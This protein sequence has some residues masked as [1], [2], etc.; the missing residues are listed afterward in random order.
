MGQFGPF[1]P[2][3]LDQAPLNRPIGPCFFRTRQGMGLM[4]R[5]NGNTFLGG[6]V[7]WW[8]ELASLLH[9]VLDSALKIDAHKSTKKAV[10][11]IAVTRADVDIKEINE[12]F[13]RIY[14]VS[15]TE[16]IEQTANG[17]YK[18]LLLTLISKGAWSR[19]IDGTPWERKCGLK[20]LHHHFVSSISVD[21]WWKHVIHSCL[22]FTLHY[23]SLRLS[24]K[25]QGFSSISKF[26]KS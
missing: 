21:F 8:S 20:L 25:T 17:N 11:R 3:L 13:N 16:R 1:Q 14:G 5:S 22:V 6:I 2:G 24:I 9:Q 12:E 10:T 19:G 26:I 23:R 7:D 4:V 15:L 18:D